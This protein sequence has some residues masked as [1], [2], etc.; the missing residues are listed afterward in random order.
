MSL[1]AHQ[2]RVMSRL[3][4]D[5][6]ALDARKRRV[7]LESLSSEYRD[8]A[9]AL[10]DA[11]LTAGTA[12][13]ARDCLTTLPKWGA[14]VPSESVPASG[15]QCG[16][17]VGPY[18]LI[19][20]LGTGGMA[21]VWLARRADG[22]F[23]REVALKL[24]LLTR[25]RKDLAERFARERDILAA[26]EHPHIARLYDA[27]V[28]ALGLPYLAMEYVPGAPL[29]SWCD[30]RRLSIAERLHLFL[31]VLEAAQYAHDR[32][33][34]HRDLKPSNILVTKSGQAL[35]LD[36]GVAKL[37]VEPVEPPL[38]GLYGRALT[39]A[40]ASPEVWRGEG[41]D[42]R[43]D[44]YS[45]GV[46][47]YEL[48]TGR[49]PY[50][51][52]ELCSSGSLERAIDTADVQKPSTRCDLDPALARSTTADNLARQLRGDLD[53]IILKA[54][55]KEPAERYA[56][57]SA[58]AA[59]LRR[60][61][62][63]QPIL[64]RPSPL[65]YRARKFVRR[66][67][68]LLAVTAIASIMALAG[69]S[70]LQRRLTDPLETIEVA[71][72]L[73]EGSIAVLPFV[74][75]SEK[76]D[77]E[78]LAEGI[79]EQIIDSLSQVRD[80]RVISRASMLYFKRR[81]HTVGQVYR[82][83]GAS[84][85]LEGSLR[86]SDDRLQLSVQLIRTDTG[87]QLWSQTYDFTAGE[88][89]QIHNDIAKAVVRALG[90][91]LPPA[92]GSSERERSGSA[93]A[94]FQYLLSIQFSLKGEADGYR[95]A[96]AALRKAVSIDPGYAPAYAALSM[97]ETNGAF[98]SLDAKG[99]PRAKAAADTAIRMA[100][101]FA[102]GYRARAYVERM[103]LDLSG[104]LQDIGRA[105]ELEPGD[106][107]IKQ[108]HASVMA[109]FGRLTP[110]IAEINDSIRIDP[111]NATSWLGLGLWLTADHQLGAAER[112]LEHSLVIEKAREGNDDPIHFALGLMK[113]LERR[114]SEA[115]SDFRQIRGDSSVLAGEAMAFYSLGSR[116]ESERA[117]AAL[118]TRNSPYFVAC[119]RAWRGEKDSALNWLERAY[120]QRDPNMTDIKIDPE[121]GA[122]HAEPRFKAILKKMGL[123]D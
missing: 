20:L 21:E 29:T 108:G 15:L 50:E 75:M 28:D 84:K 38:T 115:L 10:R 2:M 67:Q 39:P 19:R 45:L 59:D 30:A 89:F 74:D 100:P 4:D 71:T 120:A 85:A 9:P 73:G 106:A 27:G 87:E 90:T 25:L 34:I 54:L 44:Q 18:E 65:S 111:L 118:M 109:D 104:A 93:D 26:L 33:V 52:E 88:L 92:L 46:L 82:I 11:L 62:Q 51:F 110:A 12:G 117:L 86:T 22:A 48:M 105:L 57:V 119:V 55:A 70:Y 107:R 47:L 8:L 72:P 91:T 112:A 69:G 13:S 68:F 97:A 79:S 83:L 94:Y 61:L 7:W 32:Q 1:T 80:L 60:H 53:V 24:P 76:R 99:Y 17:R 42:V 40:Y 102:L 36:F 66:N 23:K 3:L 49:R 5:A 103:T 31:Q 41:L 37:L 96:I 77:H 43:S 98:Y 6:L 114:P 78:Y 58:L 116:V 113:L 121:F 35:L 81:S 95:R 16:Q 123:P 14:D 64:A 63:H 101:T 56:S 122:L